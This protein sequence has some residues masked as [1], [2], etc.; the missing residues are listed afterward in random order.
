[1]SA[2][3]SIWKKKVFRFQYNVCSNSLWF[4]KFTPVALQKKG[5]GSEKLAKDTKSKKEMGW[6]L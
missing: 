3:I 6:Y 1:M 2:S 5:R 4:G